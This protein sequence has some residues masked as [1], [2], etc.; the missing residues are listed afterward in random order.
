MSLCP[1]CASTLTDAV[2]DDGGG[3]LAPTTVLACFGCG[4]LWLD[5]E[6]TQQLVKGILA[7]RVFAIAARATRGDASSANPYRQAPNGACPSCNGTLTAVS[8]TRA[9]HGID[10]L[11]LDICG[12]H[13][14][15]FDAHELATLADAIDQKRVDDETRA[16]KREAQL[17]A[18]V[19]A[20]YPDHSGLRSLIEIMAT[21]GT[22]ATTPRRGWHIP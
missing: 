4:G 9:R 2:V 17:N 6:M 16:A 3:V 8:T 13:G 21:A 12:S 18:E 19:A 14:T 15:W 22:V 10:G 11:E 1:K 5:N 20:V 7:N